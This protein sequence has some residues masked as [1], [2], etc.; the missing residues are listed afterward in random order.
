MSYRAGRILHIVLMIWV[1]L[2]FLAAWLSF[3]HGAIDARGNVEVWRMFGIGPSEPGAIVYPLIRTAA[4]VALLFL[5]W[6][7]PN[8]WG[9]WLV[10]ALL[11][12]ILGFGL[13]RLAAGPASSFD[14]GLALDCLFFALAAWWALRA[15]PLAEAGPLGTV[16]WTLLGLAAALLPVQYLLLHADRGA[17]PNGISGVMLVALGWLLI[18]AGLAPWRASGEGAGA[19]RSGAGDA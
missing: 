9:R 12:L 7:A 4:G 13:Y 10:P 14:P 6:R 2:L 18:G 5:G 3:V 8:P 17:G 11:A 1:T 15:P 19:R 16:N